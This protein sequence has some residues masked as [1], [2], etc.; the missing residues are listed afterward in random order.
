MAVTPAS[1]AVGPAASSKVSAPKAGKGGRAA[2]SL[3]QEGVEL[4]LCAGAIY[5]CFLGYGLLHERLYKRRYGDEGERFTH[6]LFLVACQSVGNC[7]F[8]AVRQRS[9]RTH[10]A[11]AQHPHTTHSSTY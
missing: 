3:V 2:K 11:A 4:A 6:S 5:L 1:T 10:S 7:A 8:A 9:S